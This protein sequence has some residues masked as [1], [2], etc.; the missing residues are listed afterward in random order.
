MENLGLA[1]EVELLPS[2]QKALDLAPS[3]VNK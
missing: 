3:T 2:T 1:V